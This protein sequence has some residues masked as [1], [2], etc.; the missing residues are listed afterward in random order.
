[1]GTE[2]METFTIRDM[3]INSTDFNQ[4]LCDFG[5]KNISDC[6]GEDG[7]AVEPKG[8]VNFSPFQPKMLLFKRPD[9]CF[10]LKEM[11]LHRWI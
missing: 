4:I 5:I 6:G 7:S 9:G 2:I 3:L 10:L 8:K 11:R 1:M